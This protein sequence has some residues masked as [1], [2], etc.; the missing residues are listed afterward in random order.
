MFAFIGTQG[1]SIFSARLNV[2]S[3]GFENIVAAAEVPRPTFVMI[4]PCRDVLY[5]VSEVGNAGDAFGS[6]LSFS[7]DRENASLKQLSQ[8]TSGGGGPT[9]LTLDKTGKTLFAANFGGGEVSAFPVYSN[10][11]LGPVR[12][13]QINRGSGPHRRQRNAHAHGVTV[14]P[15]QR[16]LLV[17]DM[18]ADRIFIHRY[19]AES[20]TIDAAERV[21]IATPGSGPRLILFG[22]DGSFAYMLTELSA[23]IYVLKWHED[24]G[25]LELLQTFPLEAKSFEEPRSA[26]ALTIS[27]DGHLLYV[28][29]RATN[30]IEVYTIS[31]GSGGLT[32]RQS[33]SAGGK[34][35]WFVEIT[36]DEKLLAVTNQ[37]SDSVQFLAR[38]VAS[39]TL[40][41]F[42]DAI[43][44]STPTSISFFSKRAY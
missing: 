29:N 20:G 25:K 22:A 44:V 32:H 6:I 3:G 31:P 35:P 4:D 26:S 13:V 18:G 2:S 40:S 15:S 8:Q 36:P 14:D 10:G 30:T 38:D 11:V 39:G 23:E 1:N 42:G 37:A 28:S 19:N 33:I 24:E 5:A 43:N 16:Y 34:N 9:H 7:I 17:P 12:S 41:L 27:V 21:F